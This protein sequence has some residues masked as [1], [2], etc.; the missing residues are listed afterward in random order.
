[1]VKR[2]T[3]PTAKTHTAFTAI[4]ET[5]T[6][7]SIICAVYENMYLLECHLQWKHQPFQRPRVGDL[8][9]TSL[10]RTST[11]FCTLVREYRIQLKE[12]HE[13]MNG[14]PVTERHD[15]IG[16]SLP[17]IP[18]ANLAVRSKLVMWMMKCA[19][20]STTKGEVN[21]HHSPIRTKT[22]E[23]CSK[24][25]WRL[26]SELVDSM[27]R[28]NLVRTIELAELFAEWW[29]QS[30]RWAIPWW[31]AIIAEPIHAAVLRELLLNVGL[32][33]SGGWQVRGCAFDERLLVKLGARI[34][35]T[36]HGGVGLLLVA[37]ALVQMKSVTFRSAVNICACL[38][39]GRLWWLEH[40]CGDE[41]YHSSTSQGS[42]RMEIDDIVDTTKIG[43]YDDAICDLYR[44]SVH[45]VVQMCHAGVSGA[46]SKEE[47]MGLSSLLF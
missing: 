45:H 35:D 25:G 21:V 15:Y 44:N 37:D 23:L 11:I 40:N 12:E 9:L 26:V 47:M 10:A 1:M 14:Y 46:V 39:I 27:G 3:P 42:H 4:L 5:D 2:S 18:L 33:Q 7:R 30:I 36:L 29:D 20:Q 22:I 8:Y 19:Q 43:L 16:P 17:S 13:K 28:D 31:M 41:D 38:A 6:L 32:I 34:S 24:G